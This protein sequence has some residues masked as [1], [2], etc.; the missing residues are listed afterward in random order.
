M[1]SYVCGRKEFPPAPNS[2]S[3]FTDSSTYITAPY[4]FF[5]IYFAASSAFYYHEL[6]PCSSDF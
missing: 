1:T 3:V 5:Y 4:L 2:F 6:A